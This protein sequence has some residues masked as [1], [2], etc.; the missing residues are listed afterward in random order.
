MFA[1]VAVFKT[2]V[3]T[4]GEVKIL[5]RCLVL[6]YTS[7]GCSTHVSRDIPNMAAL[8]FQIMR[9]PGES[10]TSGVHVP[11]FLFETHQTVRD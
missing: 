2:S 4:A 11:F 6:G 8:S 5:L 7:I 1:R 10:W 9:Y 3:L